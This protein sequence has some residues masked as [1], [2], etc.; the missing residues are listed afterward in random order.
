M[1]VGR[2]WVVH[3]VPVKCPS[4]ASG[5]S[6]GRSWGVIWATHGLRVRR[7]WGFRGSPVGCPLGARGLCVD[8]D[9]AVLVGFC[10]FHGCFMGISWAT[11]G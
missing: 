4:V 10:A 6:V 8:Q 1:Y 7:P 2:P 9:N 11:L 3:G 5:V